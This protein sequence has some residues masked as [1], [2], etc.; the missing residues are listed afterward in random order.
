LS[1]KLGHEETKSLTIGPTDN[2]EAHKQYAQGLSFWHRRTTDDLKKAIDYFH[3][4]TLLDTKF[5]RAYAFLADSHLQLTLY[6]KKRV[7]EHLEESV[8]LANK[9][10]QLDPTI[11]LPHASLGHA[12]FVYEWD[13]S[14]A[15]KHFRAAQLLDPDFSH[16]FRYH[17]EALVAQGRFNEALEIAKKVN[18]MKGGLISHTL[19]PMVLTNLGKF[20]E[21]IDYLEKRI[22]EEPTFLMYSYHLVWAYALNG[23]LDKALAVVN[24]MQSVIGNS[25]LIGFESWI[26]ALMGETEEAR[27]HL[28]MLEEEYST[29][30]D[31]RERVALVLHALGEDEKALDQLETLLE[32]RGQLI[33]FLLYQVAWK[34]LY[35]HPRYQAILRK[36]NLLE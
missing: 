19:Y 4:A 6:G 31:V 8:R 13:W 5:A 33:G 7:R 29:G 17:G 32:E 9:A 3:Q 28:G 16:A 23:D 36:L 30:E 10:I 34:K 21:A 35:S 27:Q 22:R 12:K 25:D 20:D 2:P 11:A 14:A 1:V 18:E 15:E 26:L 24:Q